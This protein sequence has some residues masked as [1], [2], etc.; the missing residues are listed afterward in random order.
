[1]VVVV[2]VMVPADMVGCNEGLCH[3]QGVRRLPGSKRDD[4]HQE[5]LLRDADAVAEEGVA[6]VVHATDR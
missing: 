2:V 6:V 4:L 5:G 3:H 1:M